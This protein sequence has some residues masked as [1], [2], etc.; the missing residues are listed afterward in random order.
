MS[1]DETEEYVQD[2]LGNTNRKIDTVRAT[3]GGSGEA[4]GGLVDITD[5]ANT[6]SLQTL[7]SIPEYADAVYVD[8]VRAYNGSA[9]SGS[10]FAL[11]EVET[12]DSGNVT[13]STR[14]STDVVVSQGDSVRQEYNGEKF[15]KEIAVES[16]F[17]GQVAI[18]VTVDRKEQNE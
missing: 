12:D 17:V 4:G 7:Y 16:G 9:A 2:S 15:T 6:D 8:D 1:R 13:E 5:S 18:G 10:E 14:R 11:Y 3:E